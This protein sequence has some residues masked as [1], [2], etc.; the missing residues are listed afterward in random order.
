MTT[1]E[2]LIAVEDCLSVRGVSLE[3]FYAIRIDKDIINLQ[4][5]FDS[6]IVQSFSESYLWGFTS[7][8]YVETRIEI[9]AENGE[10]IPVVIT[11]T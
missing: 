10:K 3:S 4:G 11:L 5:H 6:K 1:S 8:G 9:P 7:Y 2:R